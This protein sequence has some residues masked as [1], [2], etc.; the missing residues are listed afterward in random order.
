MKKLPET[1]LSREEIFERMESYRGDDLDWR[2]GKS[3]G[4]VYDPGMEAYALVQEA[5]MK[6]LAENALD[7]TV[8]PSL[9]K[10]E[11]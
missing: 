5:Y 10:L 2:E 7:P 6:Y 8:Y 1:G 4:Y 9:L 3:F 11:I